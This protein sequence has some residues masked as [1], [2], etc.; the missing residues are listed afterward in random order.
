MKLRVLFLKKIHI[1]YVIFLIIFLSGIMLT[2]FSSVKE[3][4]FATA[5]ENT[6]L[7][8]DLTGDGKEDTLYINTED[9]K[10][11][12]QVNSG[13]KSFSI[14]PDRKL[15]SLG[16][17]YPYNPM[18]ISFMDITRDKVP[19]I[20]VQ[21]MEK[22]FSIQH[23]F[24]WTGSG[25]KDLFCSNNN[26]MGIIDSKNS[27]TPKF[28]SGL[29]SPNSINSSYYMQLGN[30]LENI[31]YNAELPGK[32]EI[33]TFINYIQSL[34]TGESNKPA[35]IFYPGITGTDLSLIGKLSSEGKIYK[36]NDAF[37]T[38]TKYNKDGEATE[39]KWIMNFR[40]TPLGRNEGSSNISVIVKLKRSPQPEQP[41]KIF[42]L[43]QNN[44]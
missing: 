23:I 8:A 24:S 25:F 37:F 5:R 35:D 1:L 33:L 44:N 26:I 10:Y 27:R 14:L 39:Y 36:F 13:S 4:V 42:S 38:D 16:R 29:F 32:N 30:R 28:S 9:D 2:V 17:Y 18:K 22:G 20:F 11:Y 15:S 3:D 7:K 12:L 43:S 41:F 21:A 34:P 40:A 19:E 31:S 6:I